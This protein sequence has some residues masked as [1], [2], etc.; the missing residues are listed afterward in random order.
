M[1]DEHIKH[2]LIA[3]DEFS[4]STTK[5]ILENLVVHPNLNSAKS[6]LLSKMLLLQNERDSLVKKLREAES[7]IDYHQYIGL[8]PLKDKCLELSNRITQKD[9]K[10]L[11]L[12]YEIRNQKSKIEELEDENIALTNENTTLEK[13]ITFLLKKL[14][15]PQKDI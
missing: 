15:N 11:Q 8:S 2:E 7:E 10:I 3:L 1:N 12:Q 6:L 4:R 13:R 9:L 14:V 5:Y